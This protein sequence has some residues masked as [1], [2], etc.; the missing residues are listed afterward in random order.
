MVGVQVE[1]VREED[2]EVLHDHL[3]RRRG[4]RWALLAGHPADEGAVGQDQG[5]AEDPP[6]RRL[7][8]LPE[9]RGVGLDFRGGLRRAARECGRVVLPRR[10]LLDL[11][12]QLAHAHDVSLPVNVPAGGRRT[13]GLGQQREPPGLGVLVEDEGTIEEDGVHELG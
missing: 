13:N 10:P 6:P 3:G 11:V 2:A 5:L 4:R 9:G 12:L 7:E 1:D 8:G